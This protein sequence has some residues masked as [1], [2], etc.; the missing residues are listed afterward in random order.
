MAWA[1]DYQQD[2]KKYLSNIW[3]II[4]WDVV[5]D[6]INIKK[7]SSLNIEIVKLSNIMDSKGLYKD[8]DILD[9]ALRKNSL[10]NFLNNGIKRNNVDQVTLNTLIYIRDNYKFTNEAKKIFNERLN[11]IIKTREIK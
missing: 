3:R 10:S 11:N 9:K 8:A 2:K 1:L 5:N 6:R 4:N 7:E